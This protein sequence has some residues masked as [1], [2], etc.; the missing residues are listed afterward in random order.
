MKIVIAPLLIF[1]SYTL[2]CQEIDINAYPALKMAKETSLYRNDVD[3]DAITKKYVQLYNQ[4]SDKK[5]AYEY[6]INSLGD[7]HGAFRNANTFQT[8]AYYTKG[9]TE[10]RAFDSHFHNTVINDINA[11]FSYRE[12]EGIGY[13]KVV[14]IGPQFPMEEDAAMIQNAIAKLKA[15]GVDKWVLDLRYNGGGNMNPMLS[16]LSSLIGSG[17][18]GGLSDKSG[19]ELQN[20]KIKKGKFYDTGN[21]V[22]NIK[23]PVKK[24]IKDR[25]AVLLSKYTASS[26]EIVAVTFKGRK[27]TRF[28]GERTRGLTT[29]TGFDRIDEETIMLI[30][31]AYYRDRNN[32]IYTNGVEVDEEIEFEEFSELKEDKILQRSIEWLNN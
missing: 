12:M 10:T 14:G 1:L 5:A 23:N 18:I 17:D 32:Q 15:K 21:Q 20:F 16:G 11:R 4:H 8:T 13:L 19:T 30:S 7:E 6:L 25:V 27:H 28:F 24:K 22:I 3:W 29:V 31:K 2:Y 9:K 26:G